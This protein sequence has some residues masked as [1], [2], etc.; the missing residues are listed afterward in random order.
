MHLADRRSQE[1]VDGMH[2]FLDVAEDNK[3]PSGDM[4]CPCGQ[5]KNQKSYKS[6]GFFT[7]I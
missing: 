4:F 6:R 1:W 2:A 3:S 7:S 5:C